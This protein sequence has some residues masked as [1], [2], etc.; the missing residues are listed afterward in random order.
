MKHP[1]RDRILILLCAALIMVGAVALVL[2]TFGLIPAELIGQVSAFVRGADGTVINKVIVCVTAFVLAL[3]ALFLLGILLPGRKKRSQPFAVISSENGAVNISVKALE[4]LVQKCLR[5]HPE[6][7][8]VSSSIFSEGENVRITLHITLFEDISIPLAVSALQ[9]EIKQYVQSCAG[10]EIDDVR[11][12]VDGTTGS[13]DT[14]VSPYRIAGSI[15]ASAEFVRAQS[16]EVAQTQKTVQV[17]EDT[18]KNAP[19]KD[20]APVSEPVMDKPASEETQDLAH[21]HADAPA[22]PILTYV[23]VQEEPAREE[24]ESVQAQ[25]NEQ[26]QEDAPEASNGQDHCAQL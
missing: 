19:V 20:E 16:G 9:K 15:G 3:F 1:V 2:A 6:L 5:A 17:Q 12:Y 13:T 4:N 7:T 14:V 21:E 11:V 22:D 10:V 25:E 18:A 23:Q 26:A 24:D 8:V